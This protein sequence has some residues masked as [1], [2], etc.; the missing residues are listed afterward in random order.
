M[1]INIKIWQFILA[2]CLIIFIMHVTGYV[3]TIILFLHL[4]KFLFTDYSFA[5]GQI[6]FQLIDVLI[7]TTLIIA[8]PVFIYKIKNRKTI[9]NNKL[10]F[11]SATIIILLFFFIFA[12]V[13]AVSNPDFQKNLR[14]TK[15][16]PPMSVVHVLYLKSEIDGRDDKIVAFLKLK[17]EVVKKSFDNYIIFIDSLK[18]GQMVTYFQNGEA[19]KIEREKIKYTSGAPLIKDRI[20]LLGTDE[21]GR[22]IFSRLVFGTRISMFVGFCAV[23]IS[24]ILGLSF[25]FI[26]GFSSGTVDVLFNRFTDMLLAF[27][28][29]FLII[30]ILALFGNNLPAVIF[31]LGFSGWM[32]LFKIVR[33]EVISIK[34]KEYFI[35]SKMI[36]LSRINLLVKEVL[37]VIIASVIV[38]LVFQYGNVI[39]AEAALSFLGLGTGSSYPSWGQMIEAGQVY[40][41]SAW[42]MIVFPG[43]ILFLTLFAA[44]NFGREINEFFNPRI[45][46]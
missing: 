3:D 17:D 42:W 11:T 38:N 13:I 1:K 5:S 7:S 27:P 43:I 12:P 9:L 23:V 40:I 33:S 16:L 15:L 39:L 31:V 37:P 4:I 45:K 34:N 41:T 18:Q 10:N 21:F 26:A 2:L 19:H 36:G 29:V 30:L 44:Y 46:I 20:F 28:M 8:I 35:T 14:V 32:S 24:L 25:G 22:D 6:T